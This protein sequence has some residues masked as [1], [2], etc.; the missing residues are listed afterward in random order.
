MG[1]GSSVRSSALGAVGS[2]LQ[3]EQGVDID[4][5]DIVTDMD[6]Y[7]LGQINSRLVR[8]WA[9][10]VGEAI[11]WYT[12]L[13]NK[14]GME[15]QLEWNMPKKFRYK[16]WPTGHG[17][18]GEYP[19]REGDVAKIIDAYITSFEGCEERFNTPM[20]RLIVENSHVVGLYAE[21]S[22]GDP[23]RMATPR[24]A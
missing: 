9:E 1:Q 8:L 3:Q 20:I 14:N 21:N 17:T 13:M 18:N 23:I 6:H 5:M 11:D 7:A 15:V 2:K 22:D 19:S 12:D 16:E 4:V 10:E 24:K